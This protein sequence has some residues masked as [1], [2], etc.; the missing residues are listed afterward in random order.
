[1]PLVLVLLG[2]MVAVV[3]VLIFYPPLITFLPG[4]LFE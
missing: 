4:L 3:L 2:M 1:L